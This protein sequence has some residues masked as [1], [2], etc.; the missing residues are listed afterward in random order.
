MKPV[1]LFVVLALGCA[2]APP[3][4]TEDVCGVAH[5]RIGYLTRQ[6]EERGRRPLPQPPPAPR[7]Q[8]EQEQGAGAPPQ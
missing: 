1:L 7:P 3:P 2:T 8:T 6:L 4:P 5:E